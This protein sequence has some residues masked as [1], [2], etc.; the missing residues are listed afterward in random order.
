[1]NDET[2][3]VTG[4]TMGLMLMAIGEAILHQGRVIEFVDHRPMYPDTAVDRADE[5]ATIVRA[6]DICCVIKVSCNRVFIVSEYE[7]G[8]S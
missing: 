3:R 5:M 4:R 8:G 2:N 6:L 1:M 7:G